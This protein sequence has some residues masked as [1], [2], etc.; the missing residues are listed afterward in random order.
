MAISEQTFA[1]NVANT[2]GEFARVV[3]DLQSLGE[4][5]DA[6]GGLATFTD[7]ALTDSG[8]TGNQLLEI[9]YLNNDLQAFLDNGTPPQANRWPTVQRH[10]GDL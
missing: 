2:L 4:I 10:R 3:E 6:R 5:Y 9:I 1:A 7:E 8:F